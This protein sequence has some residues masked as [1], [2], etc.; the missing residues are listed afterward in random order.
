D[1]LS[2]GGCQTCRAGYW[3][4]ANRRARL[5]PSRQQSCPIRGLDK[6]PPCRLRATPS[7][8]RVATSRLR[9]TP[10]PATSPLWPFVFETF[11]RL[12]AGR[13]LAGA[14]AGQTQDD[15][16]QKRHIVHHF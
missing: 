8:E 3:P 4:A 7:I 9:A 10:A 1:S 5:P 2:S 11:D 14:H 12:E 6:A 15:R 13:D 16:F